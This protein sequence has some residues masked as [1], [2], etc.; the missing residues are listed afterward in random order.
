MQNNIFRNDYSFTDYTP[1]LSDNYY[2]L[3]M[4]DPSGKSEYSSIRL[5][6]FGKQS[7]AT[8]YPN[9]AHHQLQL[10]LGQMPEMPLS[11]SVLDANGKYIMNVGVIRTAKTSIEIQQ[12]PA[13]MYTLRLTQLIS[14]NRYRDIQ[15][16]K[17]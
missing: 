3:K 7:A 12:L 5:V 11:G 13:G 9:P 2:R 10:D 6:R 14:G 16:I 4:A 17:Q 15:F 8:V 1:V